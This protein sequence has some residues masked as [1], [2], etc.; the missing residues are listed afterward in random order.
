MQIGP[1]KDESVLSRGIDTTFI[2][3]KDN[4]PSVRYVGKYKR[5]I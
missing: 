3:N 4:I 2:T 5:N 1:D